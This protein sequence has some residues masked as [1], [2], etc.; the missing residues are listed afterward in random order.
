MIMINRKFF[1]VLLLFL[2]IV[3]PIVLTRTVHR[4]QGTAHKQKVFY[5]DISFHEEVTQIAETSPSYEEIRYLR[6]TLERDG[7]M[8]EVMVN[9]TDWFGNPIQGASVRLYFNQ[10]EGTDKAKG[11]V[12]GLTDTSGRFE[13]KKTTTY[14]C[15]WRIEKNGFYR[16]R[17]ILPFSNHFSFSLGKEKRWT[18]SPLQVNAILDK[19]S[20][21]KLLHGFI[22]IMDLAIPTNTWAAF[23]FE[24]NDLVKPYG[25]GINPHLS[26]YSVGTGKP[27]DARL[28]GIVWTNQLF[29]SAEGGGISLLRQRENTD[30][31]FCYEAPD[32]FQTATLEFFSTRSRQGMIENREMKKDEY[33]VFQ[34]AGNGDTKGNPHFGIIRNLEYWPGGLRMEYF[35]NPVPGDRRTDV[36]I[37]SEWDLKR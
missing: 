11:V 16:A 31:P 21:A 17:G 30:M 29:I 4:I 22:G 12:E 28:A 5:S 25:K 14:A 19:R 37:H 2:A 24:A 20:G 6:H 3:I 13:A 33:I 18:A 7:A 8:A 26:F 36:D 9:A 32:T 15:P 23:D 35:F 1:F 34:T 27:R 10:P